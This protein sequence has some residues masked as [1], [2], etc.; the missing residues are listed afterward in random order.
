M[1]G[2]PKNAGK[3]PAFQF[4]PN[5]WTRDLEEHPLE[6]E[7]AWIRIVCKLWYATPNRGLLSKTLLQWSRILREP[8]LKTKE[9]FEYFKKENIGNITF[10]SEPD[11]SLIT[12]SCRRMVRDEMLRQKNR[13]RQKEFRKRQRDDGDVTG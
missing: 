7:G 8:E 13:L 6:I 4:Y 3:A 10:H 12:V 1:K 5:D 2:I 9:L 11:T